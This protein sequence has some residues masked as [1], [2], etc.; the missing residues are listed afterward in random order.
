MI[1]HEE[2][3]SIGWKLHLQLLES[4]YGGKS[5]RFR[6]ASIDLFPKLEDL[7]KNEE[8]VHNTN[9]FI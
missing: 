7:P 3:A 2:K 1:S 5:V 6:R 8:N 4:F 9:D